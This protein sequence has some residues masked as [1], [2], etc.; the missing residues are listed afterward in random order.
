MKKD[1]N[2]IIYNS[3][4]IIRNAS[5]LAT[6]SVFY[7]KVLLPYTTAATSDLF[8]GPRLINIKMPR[9]FDQKG[10][11]EFFDDVGYWSRVYYDLLS[12][13]VIER[14]PAPPWGDKPPLDKLVTINLAE[15]IKLLTK[16]P[17]RTAQRYLAMSDKPFGEGETQEN[18]E[19]GVLREDIIKQDLALHFLRPDLELPQ[20][21]IND[22]PKPSREFLKAIEAR[23]VF[24]YLLPALGYLKAEEILEVRHKVKDLREGFSMH[25]QKLSK[26]IDDR[27]K[28]GESFEELESWAKSIIEVELIPDYREFRRQLTAERTSM[29]NKV[30]DAAA[31]IFQI[32]AAPWTLKFYAELLKAIGVTILTASAERKEMLSNRSQAYYFM[33]LVEESELSLKS[34][35]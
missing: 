35:G 17:K 7:D 9:G 12:E 26:G 16:D 6:L 24:D 10:E 8:A 21:F 20:V 27:L 30:L 4:L 14:L 3:D 2:A 25:L 31:K 34:E 5:E 1:I 11:Q 33:R 13:G 32:E 23:A 28:G 15:K 22:G 29:G 18:L 19:K